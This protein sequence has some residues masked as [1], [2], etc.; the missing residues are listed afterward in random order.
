MPLQRPA[1]GST[2]AAGTASPS[3]AA[4]MTPRGRRDYDRLDEIGFDVVEEILSKRGNAIAKV[5]ADYD[6][7]E[8]N[9]RLWRRMRR[10]RLYLDELT[11][12]QFL[13]YIACGHT[14]AEI[15]RDNELSP[16]LI[17]KWVKDEIEAQEL[18]GARELAAD[19]QFARAKGEL[20]DAEDDVGLRRAVERH[21]IDRFQAERTTKK[22]SDEKTVR[23]TGL[24]GVIFNFNT[25]RLM[26][27]IEEEQAVIQGE[28]RRLPEP[29]R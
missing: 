1:P 23:V 17:E 2:A 3:R 6:V 11:I 29:A 10:T 7:A 26:G 19:S 20:S 18:E 27:S 5:A 21:K 16:R 28:S 22:Y 24:E 13:D 12:E 14:I 8:I 25:N 9:L 4:P 15:A